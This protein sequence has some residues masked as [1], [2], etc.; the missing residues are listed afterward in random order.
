MAQKQ[1]SISNWKSVNRGALRGFVTAT[2]PSGMVL[3]EVSIM[4]SNGRAWASPPS[5]PMLDRDGRAMVDDAGGR[6]YAPIFTFASAEIRN[7]WSSAVI[8]ALL[9]AFPEALRDE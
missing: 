8:D 1:I 6:R 7:K 9:A 4:Q 5:K 2:L 3:H